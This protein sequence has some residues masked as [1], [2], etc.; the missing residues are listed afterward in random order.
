MISP[1]LAALWLLLLTHVSS[2]DP[3]LDAKRMVWPCRARRKRTENILNLL[4]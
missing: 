4:T 1:L 2:G 3:A